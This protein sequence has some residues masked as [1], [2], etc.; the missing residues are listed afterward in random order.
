MSLD[1][2]ENNKKY[3]DIFR[4]PTGLGMDMLT[5]RF[6]HLLPYIDFDKVTG[7]LD[8]GSCHGYESLNMARLFP[9]SHVWGF[10]P[11]PDNYNFCMNHHST[12][13]QDL[14]TRIRYVNLAANDVDGEIKFYPLDRES[15]HGDNVGMASKFKLYDPRVFPHELS[16]QKEIVVQAVSLDNWCKENIVQPQI[17]WMDAQGAEG[18]ILKGAKDI[19]PSVKVILTE[20]GVKPYY[21]GHELKPD[22]DKYLNS[23]GFI[24]MVKSRK[25]GHEYEMD[26]IYIKRELMV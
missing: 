22:I 3:F 20:V 24:E 6:S 18:S 14:A 2:Y 13:P 7:V 25:L 15:S 17:L 10:E 19:L 21:I 26:T 12:M 9:N 23:F 8:I 11:T 1:I 16:I 5:E 4:N